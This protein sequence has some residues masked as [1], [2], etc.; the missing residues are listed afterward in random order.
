MVADFQYF[1]YF[2][3][4]KDSNDRY[5]PDHSHKHHELVYYY[6]GEGETNVDYKT[7]YYYKP[8]H[9]CIYRAQEMHNEIHYNKSFVYCIGFFLETTGDIEINS[10]IFSDNENE[11]WDIIRKIYIEISE[12]KQLYSNMVQIYTNEILLKHQRNHGKQQNRADPMNYI[13]RFIDENY[14]QNICLKTLADIAGYSSDHFRHLF[15]IQT[16]YSP[17]QYIINKRISYAKDLLETEAKTIQE[18][19]VICGFN[20][21]SQFTVAFKQHTLQTPTEYRKEHLGKSRA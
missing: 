13:Y 7:K 11:I 6:D 12:K 14:T 16:G 17:I 4:F 3:Y 9:Y 15:K 20:N 21:N 18:I 5:V 8:K 19:A 1:L 10:G 2:Q